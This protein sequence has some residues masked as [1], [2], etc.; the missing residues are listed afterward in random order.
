MTMHTRC[1]RRTVVAAGLLAAAIAADVSAATFAASATGGLSLVSITGDA[2]GLTFK[3]ADRTDESGARFGSLGSVS[4]DANVTY[5][6]DPLGIG[7]GFDISL[8]AVATGS[9]GTSAPSSS[10]E[11]SASAGSFL[12]LYNA[13]ATPVEIVFQFDY[14]LDTSVFE[15]PGPQFL[16]IGQARAEF[17]VSILDLVDEYIVAASEVPV[18]PNTDLQS[19]SFLAAL[20][21]GPGE[22]RFVDM[23]ARVYGLAELYVVP[24]PAAVWLL[25]SALGTVPLVRRR[26]A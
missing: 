16:N 3:P 6:V 9:A 19:S 15:T 24:A 21:L 17:Q 7:K 1:A 5:M 22:L 14:V 26:V 23:Q 10:V 13:A 20:T 2:S 18:G 25:L 12:E 4:K 8:Q 11:A